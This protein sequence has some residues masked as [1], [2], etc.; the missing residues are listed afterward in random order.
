VVSGE[1]GVGKTAL[2]EYLAEQASG[3]RVYHGLPLRD[4]AGLRRIASV[5]SPLLDSLERLPVAQRD[6]L[7]IAF[8]MGSGPIP[9]RFLVGLA[10]LNLLSTL[11]SRSHLSVWSTTSSVARSHVC[12]SAGLCCSTIGG[13]IN[14]DDERLL[15][16]RRDTAEIMM[17]E[18]AI[19]AFSLA[20][21][22]NQIAIALVPARTGRHRTRSSRAVF[23]R[24]AVSPM[25]WSS[26]RRRRAFRRRA[27]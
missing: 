9:D 19:G 20:A 16:G 24:K 1:A 18:W 23:T 27:S 25:K 12:P 22:V 17:W 15:P 3:C 21:V 2:L 8:G 10:V 14:R 4:G 6:A 11:R 7:P 5:V 26:T 13:G